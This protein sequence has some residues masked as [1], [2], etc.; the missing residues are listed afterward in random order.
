[1]LRGVGFSYYW[2]LVLLWDAHFLGK[3]LHNIMCIRYSMPMACVFLMYVCTASS[4]LYL[5]LIV[6]LAR[7]S[8]V[9][10]KRWDLKDYSVLLFGLYQVV[11]DFLDL[12]H[13]P[14]YWLL[15]HFLS[16]FYCITSYHISIETLFHHIHSLYCAIWV[17]AFTQMSIPDGDATKG[18]KVFKQRCAQCHTYE[19]VSVLSVKIQWDSYT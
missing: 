7:P 14:C 13:M 1:M 10:P 2:H 9:Q 6:L 16:Y 19:K 5:L 17:C 8:R 15:H 11:S 3:Q 12:S 18:A 4:C